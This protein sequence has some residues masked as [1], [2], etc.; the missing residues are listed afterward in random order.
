[1][2]FMQELVG[3]SYKD[4]GM[5]PKEG[6]DCFGLV[7]WVVREGL[8][9]ILPENALAWRKYGEVIEGRPK[10]IRRYDL[11]FFYLLIPD[12]A[13]HVG[14][15]NSYKDFTHAGSTFGAVVCEPISKYIEYIK[16]VGRIK[17]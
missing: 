10:D 14:I 7:R 9:I 17:T 3:V 16:A 2:D 13:T 1:M 12:V 4:G 8:G 11:L 5:S 6:F 15:A